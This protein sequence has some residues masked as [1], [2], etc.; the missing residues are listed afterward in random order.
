[1]TSH[2]TAHHARGETA[3]VVKTATALASVIA[4]LIGIATFNLA[5]PD[6]VPLPEPVPANVIEPSVILPSRDVVR[7]A[8]YDREVEPQIVATD[9]LNREAAD[10]CISRIESLID[11]YHSGVQPFVE[12]LTSI[13]TRLGIVKRM[14][15]DWWNDESE[16]ESYVAEKFEKHLFSEKKL[17]SDIAKVLD[18]FREEIN[19]NQ[20]RMLVLIHA[21]L[22][23][24]DLPE[25]RLDQ[26][27][28]FY[29]SISR[30]LQSY[31]TEQGTTSVYNAIVVILISEAGS[32]AATTIASG[33][34]ARF[35]TTAVVGVAAGAGTSAGAAATGAGGGSFAGPVGTVVG[36][37]VGLAV[38]LII[39]WWMTANFEAKMSDQLHQFLD[40]LNATLIEGASPDSNASGNVS[41]GEQGGLIVTLPIV[42]DQLTDAYRDQFFSKIVKPVESH[43]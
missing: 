28:L 37:G 40:Q 20:K 21:K 11:R 16:I 6:L 14:P 36:L 23:V 5:K 17:A 29:E 1:M 25:V 3:S 10:R 13:S 32:Y 30:R 39:D 34:L 19:A 8:F 22:D 33:L 42:C 12:D 26:Y 7:A 18:E 15:S 35:S 38:G 43:E 41:P 4:G 31:S 24:A 9:R 27:E 2:P